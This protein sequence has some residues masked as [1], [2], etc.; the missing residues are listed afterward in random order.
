M[1][2]LRAIKPITLPGILPAVVSTTVPDFTWV[3]PRSLLVEEVYQRQLAERSIKLIRKIVAG[4]DWA[5]M[6]PP[7]CAR[8]DN[9]GLFVIDGQHT[10]IAAASH[11]DIAEIPVMIVDA[12]EVKQRA[13]AFM[14][15]NRDRLAITQSQLYFASIAAGDEIAVATDEACRLSGA[16]IMKSVPYQGG[17]LVGETIAIKAIM[18]VVEHHGISGGVRLLGILMQAKRAPITSLEVKALDGML[19]GVAGRGIDQTDLSTVIRAKP[20]EEWQRQ[21]AMR[22]AQRDIL[23]WKALVEL[24]TAAVQAPRKAIA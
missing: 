2:G 10:A 6:K 7:I 18:N 20:A 24:W 1:N 11:P 12:P 15:H 14:G 4:W 19:F 16:K 17:W 23:Q 22:S 8:A 13:S 3:D 9:G 21:A 5:R